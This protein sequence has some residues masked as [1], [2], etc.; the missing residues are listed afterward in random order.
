[1][2]AGAGAGP[3][4]VLFVHGAGGRAGTWC[5]VEPLVRAAGHRTLAVD[6]PL[7]SLDDDVACAVA[8][9]HELVGSRGPVLCVGHSYGGAVVTGAGRDARVGGLV[10]VAAFA[11]DEGESVQ[12]LVD[13]YRPAPLARFMA[14]DADGGWHSQ[15][16]PGFWRTVAPDLTLEQRAR[17]ARERR[18]TADAVFSRPAGPAAWRRLPS[19]YVVAAGDA[20]LV[21]EAQRDMARRAG[22]V[23]CE[24]PG[25]HYTPW[26]RPREVARVVLGAAAA[27]G[28]GATGARR[29]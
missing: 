1:M 4:P 20:S 10:Y 6:L 3:V 7:T 14:R 18:A 28:A 9:L 8:A 25:S 27:L 2:N 15:Q 17:E 19:W 13:R 12:G 5:E 29:A 21:P 24:V 26:T 16:G 23:T 11:P 22:S